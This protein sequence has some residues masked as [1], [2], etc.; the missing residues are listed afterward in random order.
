MDI[1]QVNQNAA[2]VVDVDCCEQ[3]NVDFNACERYKPATITFTDLKCD[4]R[5]LSLTVNLENVCRGKQIALGV[6][7]REVI[8]NA[9]NQDCEH[10]IGFLA[11]AVTVP[12]GAP[13]ASL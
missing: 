10:T 4:G 5:M 6:I 7:V 8:K 12:S 11:L 2:E 3:K 13:G 1:L 9:Q